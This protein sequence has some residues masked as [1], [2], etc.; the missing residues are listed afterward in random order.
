MD[1]GRSKI[2]LKWLDRIVEALTIPVLIICVACFVGYGYLIAGM[3]PTL[4]WLFGLTIGYCLCRLQ[5]M[6]LTIRILLYIVIVWAMYLGVL[7]R[8]K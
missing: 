4:C 1:I 7:E 8:I 3:T 2:R 5:H 6:S